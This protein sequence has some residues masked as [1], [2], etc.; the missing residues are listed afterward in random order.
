MSCYYYG[1]LLC[2]V[3]GSA[4]KCSSTAPIRDSELTGSHDTECRSRMVGPIRLWAGLTT[5]V[6]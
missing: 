3:E 1:W 6:E 5:D 4:T 2:T